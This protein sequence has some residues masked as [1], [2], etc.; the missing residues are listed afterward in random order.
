MTGGGGVKVTGVSRGEGKKS[1]NCTA[2]ILEVLPKF[3]NTQ[4]GPWRRASS[5]SGRQG[6]WEVT[7]IRKPWFINPLATELR[8]VGGDPSLMRPDNLTVTC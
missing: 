8:G 4:L 1:A 6:V 3:N 2:W 5:D 7:D